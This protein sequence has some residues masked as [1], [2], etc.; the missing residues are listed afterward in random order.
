MA[1][2]LDANLLK[3][4]APRPQLDQ[5][6]AVDR[7]PEKRRLPTIAGVAQFLD[8][9]EAHDAD[10][11]PSE[12]KEEKKQRKIAEIKRKGEES[13]AAGLL[14]WNPTADP[15]VKSDPYKTLFVGRL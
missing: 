11:V 15:Q 2:T 14:T 9:A 7:P 8:R 1:S 12:T 6:P 3:L 4:F 10:Y 13:I 5:K